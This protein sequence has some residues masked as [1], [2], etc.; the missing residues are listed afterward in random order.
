M[1]PRGEQ[2]PDETDLEISRLQA[3]VAAL[4]AQRDHLNSCALSAMNDRD[5]YKGA[6]GFFEVP[7][8]LIGGAP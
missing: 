7:D 5:A 3:E 2:S 1:S 6:L 8:A 4:K